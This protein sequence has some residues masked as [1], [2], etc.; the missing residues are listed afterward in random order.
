MGRV[1]LQGDMR[2]GLRV[3]K[4]AA[5]HH[6]GINPGESLPWLNAPMTRPMNRK[7]HTVMGVYAPPARA[8]WQAAALVALSMGVVLG[9]PAGLMIDRLW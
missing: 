7:R 2:K 8:T 5:I 4:G 6:G 1:L 9:L 3:G